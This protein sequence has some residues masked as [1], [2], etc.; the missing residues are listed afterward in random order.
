MLN[1]LLGVG[2]SGT[3][4]ISQSSEPYSLTFSKT[5]IVSTIALLSLLLVTAVMV[6][7]NDFFLT[8]RWGI[9]LVL[10][11]LVIMIVNVVVEIKT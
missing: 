3:Y 5:L 4:V 11:Y 9:F 7:L 6:P 10:A 2:I 1:I 8:R